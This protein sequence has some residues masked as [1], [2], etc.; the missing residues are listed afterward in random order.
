MT[1]YFIFFPFRSPQPQTPSRTRPRRRTTSDRRRRRAA[2]PRSTWWWRSRLSAGR[3]GGARTARRT[4][5]RRRRAGRA[6]LRCWP[7]ARRTAARPWTAPAATRK[8]RNGREEET[9]ARC[10]INTNKERTLM[11]ERRSKIG[12]KTREEGACFLKNLQS[13]CITFRTNI[14]F[15]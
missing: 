9:R 5:G 14:W 3:G 1:F 11:S 15:R 10:K 4:G 7:A 2:G 13:E 8:R 12:E 6:G